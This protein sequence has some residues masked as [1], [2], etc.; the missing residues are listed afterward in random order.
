MLFCAVFAMLG[1]YGNN[2]VEDG[3]P[4]C[5]KVTQHVIG[6]R[7]FL[8]RLPGHATCNEPAH[9]LPVAVLIH[10]YGCDAFMEID[11]FAAAADRL[12]FGLAAPEGIERSF[13]APS[14]CGHARDTQMGDVEFIDEIASYLLHSLSPPRFHASALFASGFSNG[15]FLASQLA[16][17]SRTAWAGLAPVAG[18]EYDL[19]VHTRA[20]ILEAP[21]LSHAPPCPL[22]HHTPTAD[23]G[24]HARLRAPLRRRQHGQ[25]QRLLRPR[26]SRRARAHRDVLLRHTPLAVRLPT[27]L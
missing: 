25:R 8:L 18:H 21:S 5:G 4:S 2:L 19:Q 22:L 7:K 24:A 10:C 16:D 15:G 14:C 9:P 3:D 17:T 27:P 11:K 6:N 26:P 13:N 20:G 23:Q 12:G 1:R